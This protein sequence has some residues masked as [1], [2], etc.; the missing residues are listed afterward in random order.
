ML[1]DERGADVG[2]Q[3]RRGAARDRVDLSQIASAITRD[4]SGEVENMNYG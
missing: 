3:Q 2:G 1:A 4:Q